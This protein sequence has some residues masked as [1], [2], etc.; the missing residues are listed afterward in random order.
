[1]CVVRTAR[2]L[3]R[4]DAAAHLFLRC[5]R[6]ACANANE[7]KRD[8]TYANMHTVEHRYDGRTIRNHREG[9]GAISVKEAAGGR[10]QGLLN[11][12]KTCSEKRVGKPVRSFIRHRT[13]VSQ[14]K[15]RK[16]NRKSP[17]RRKS[18]KWSAS[19]SEAKR[20]SCRQDNM[21]ARYQRE[22][23]RPAKK[24]KKKEKKTFAWGPCRSLSLLPP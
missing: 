20:I 8:R 11:L 23:F 3:R 21:E 24:M 6:N 13:A 10:F 12:P 1:M 18:R 7:L 22:V 15:V 4:H 19:E 16:K 9:R 5:A 2:S 17:L 14:K